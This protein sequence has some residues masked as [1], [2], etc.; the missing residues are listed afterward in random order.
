MAGLSNFLWSEKQITELSEGTEHVVREY[1]LYKIP[2]KRIRT[3][4]ILIEANGLSPVNV[5]VDV[6]LFLSSNL[7]DLNVSKLTN[8]AINHG[9]NYIDQFLENLNANS[10]NT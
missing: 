6:T 7:T 2:K 8:E 9:F 10:T 4:E 5:S 1:I 3:L